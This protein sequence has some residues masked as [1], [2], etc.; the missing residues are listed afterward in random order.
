MRLVTSAIFPPSPMRANGTAESR[1]GPSAFTSS[2]ARI[3]SKSRSS[4]VSRRRIPALSI[5]TSTRVPGHDPRH[6]GPQLGLTAEL[7]KGVGGGPH[8]PAEQP[9]AL[10]S[11][12]LAQLRGQGEHH[13][14]VVHREQPLPTRGPLAASDVTDL[15]ARHHAGAAARAA[16]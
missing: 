5:S 14:A 9:T 8:Q 11:E 7:E 2:C 3:L 12:E 1:S 10:G 6:L 13:V 4:R 15:E 16:P